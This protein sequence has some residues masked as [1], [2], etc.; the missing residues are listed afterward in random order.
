MIENEL[1]KGV[2]S[3]EQVEPL[4]PKRLTRQTDRQFVISVIAPTRNE[5]GNIEPLLRRIDQ[6]GLEIK[7]TNL[8]FR[9]LHLLMSRPG[10]IFN[11]GDIIETIWGGYG[12]RDHVLLKECGLSF[13]K[14]IGA[15]PSHP[16]LLQTEQG[17][18]SFQVMKR[19]CNFILP[20]SS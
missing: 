8:E 16:A 18:Y 3:S 17:G 15:D 2:V 19:T 12:D 14:K 5:A 13:A 10:H 20:M 7:L 9:L 4:F 11:A 1:L 6:N